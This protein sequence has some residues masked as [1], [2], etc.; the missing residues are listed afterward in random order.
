MAQTRKSGCPLCGA[1]MGAHQLWAAAEEL[2]NE[3]LEVYGAQCPFCQGYLEIQ[4]QDEFLN[5]GYL[6]GTGNDARFDI[7]MT[8]PFNT[9]T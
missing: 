3:T 7:A 2:I 4:R 1:K 5:I 8:L 6:I 9:L